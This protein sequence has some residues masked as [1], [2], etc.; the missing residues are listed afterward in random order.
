MSTKAWKEEAAEESQDHRS[1]RAG[2]DLRVHW[3]QISHLR[4]KKIK[5]KEINQLADSHSDTFDSSTAHLV[6]PL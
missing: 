6:K 4:D 1:L 5:A 3:V 2:R